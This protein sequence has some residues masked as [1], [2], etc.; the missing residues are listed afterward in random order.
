MNKLWTHLLD[1]PAAEERYRI[2][3]TLSEADA[4]LRTQLRLAAGEGLVVTEVIAES[5]AAKAGVEAHD[6]LIVLGGK[7]L[8]TVEAIN[9]QIQE[10]KDKAVELRLLRAGKELSFRI[11]PHKEQ[12]AV[13]ANPVVVWDTHQCRSCHGDAEAAHLFMGQRL[14]AAHSAWTDGHRLLR[15][16]HHIRQSGEA[17]ADSS[18]APQQ[19]IEVLKAQLT[20]M[21]KALS[22]LESALKP[23]ESKEK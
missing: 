15:F 22:A 10:I 12:K 9:S 17:P 19:Q 20:E 7:R 8:T 6:V 11:A 18:P 23:T 1:A 2:G 4:T 21:Q 14:R 5:P 3:V 13:F 16:S